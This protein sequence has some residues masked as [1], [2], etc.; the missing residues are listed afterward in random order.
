MQPVIPLTDIISIIVF[1]N[2]SL[3]LLQKV[4]KAFR[5]AASALSARDKPHVFGMDSNQTSPDNLI[6]FKQIK[7]RR[8]GGQMVFLFACEQT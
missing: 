8:V 3:L 5:L 6:S 2:Y 7:H 1:M 4:G